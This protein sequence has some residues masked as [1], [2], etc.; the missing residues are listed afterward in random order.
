MKKFELNNI[1]LLYFCISWLI[2]II[3]FLLMLLEIQDELAFSLIFLS[4]LNIIINV[5]SI[6]LLFVFYYVFPENK[7]EFKNSAILL[8]FNFPIL[9]LLYIFLILA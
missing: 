1:A 7:K 6:A 9:F 5:L 2:G 3:I 8:F 4:G